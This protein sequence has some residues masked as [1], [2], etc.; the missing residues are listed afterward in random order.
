MTNSRRQAAGLTAY[1][2]RALAAGAS[3]VA[4]AALLMTPAAV[5][6]AV[7]MGGPLPSWP[8][9]PDWHQYVEAPG[10][11]D[12]TPVR[13]VSV[14]GTVTN[15]GGVVAGGHGDTTLTRSA[16]D[17]GQTDI[18]LDYGRDVGGVPSFTV[19]AASGSPTME[20]GYSEAAEY[21]APGGDG[22]TP[23][24]GANGDPSRADS[25]TVSRPGVITNRYIQG[26][27]RYQEI[28]LTSAGSVSL[29]SVGIRYTGYA[30]TPRSYRGYF[31]SSDPTLNKEWYAGAYTLNLTQDL[32]GT[33]SHQWAIA[34]GAMNLT[35]RS[36]F[37]GTPVNNGVLRFGS[38]WRDYTSA[39]TAD[40]VSGQ[41]SWSVRARDDLDQYA[42]TLNSSAAATSPDSVVIA[43]VSHGVSTTLGTF[44]TPFAVAE[45]QAY[46]I[47]TTVSGQTIT[48]S[49]NGTVIGS[50]TDATFAAGTVGFGESGTG[51]ANVSHLVVAARNGRTLYASTLA[52][53]SAL[54]DFLTPGTPTVDL[55]LDGAKRD[56]ATFTGDLSVAAQT[57]Y[58]TN[59]AT[60]YVK[61][62][63]DL[64][65]STQLTS[66]YVSP[67]AE[68]G[69]PNT[70][71]LIPGQ[72]SVP[73]GIYSLY[74]VSDV[75]DYYRYTG[76][77]QFVAREWP[78]V[79]REM[80][81]ELAQA[82]TD[83]LFVTTPADDL[84]W[85]LESHDGVVTFY[86][87]L[88][89][90]TLADA[91]QLAGALG[92]ATLAAQYQAD[93]ARAK[94]E[95]NAQLYDPATHAY[96]ISATDR[97]S[98]A[99]DAN[100]AVILYGIAPASRQAGVLAAMTQALGTPHGDLSVSS[101]VPAGS[102]QIISPFVGS[103]DLDARFAAGD[104]SGALQLLRS[105][106]GPMTTGPDG[107]TMWEKLAPDGT[108]DG[109]G[110]SL[111]HAWSTGPTSALTS[112]VL[113]VT[114]ASPGYATWQVAPQPGSL[115]WAEGAVP[116]PH[117]DIT[118]KWAASAAGFA[119]AV[120]APAGT[121]GT[122]V[123]PKGAG[124]YSVTVNGNPVPVTPGQAAVSVR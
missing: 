55:I 83:G 10:P 19:A 119:I 7:T 58:D 29:S 11:A 117:G 34:D 109:G 68:P 98:I 42:I 54:T 46:R 123:L 33:Q 50:V 47:S 91:A 27:E 35:A 2:R 56:R 105:E 44:P 69:A 80:A 94:A 113:G 62:S 59:D 92:H 86:N 71:G 20:A 39:F 101:P 63:L 67:F 112:Y 74:F 66:G 107:G 102:T 65:G 24:I 31:V 122:V 124:R 76:D 12:L 43:K 96:D 41:V 64:L 99:Q 121:T 70:G 95:I 60:S 18:V 16:G 22:G 82:N 84:N 4:A 93:A 78:T 36:S 77:R 89:Y 49:V 104:T 21:V 6:A 85:N 116:T 108:I 110:T 90:K 103:S 72:V 106:W 51:S 25:Y 73:L 3:V 48:V 120:G 100:S 23:V 8:A 115:G 87:A 53:P 1:R 118:V 28:S 97:G 9:L 32:A 30:G 37:V 13:V 81:W 26:G 57:L 17:T 111:A 14:S 15:P 114:P 88:Y 5:G 40:V 75:G 45:N 38:T 79:Q 52:S 61:G